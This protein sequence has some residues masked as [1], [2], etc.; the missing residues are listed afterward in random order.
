MTVDGR[1]R[2]LTS[3][4]YSRSTAPPSSFSSP[5]PSLPPRPSS[6]RAGNGCSP[7]AATRRARRSRSRPKS[8]R[9]ASATP[10]AARSAYA[11]S[12]SRTGGTAPGTSRSDCVSGTTV[13]RPGARSYLLPLSNFRHLRHYLLR[14]FRRPRRRSR[15]ARRQPQLE[16]PSSSNGRHALRPQ[17][18]L[19]P[20]LR[21]DLIRYTRSAATLTTTGRRARR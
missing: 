9:A 19:P 7:T 6:P 13:I 18:I 20:K 12:S 8:R 10:K 3:P 21:P 5:R 15:R 1:D 2:Q 16:P 4:R 17:R 11:R 14:R